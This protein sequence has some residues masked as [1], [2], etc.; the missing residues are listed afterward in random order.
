MTWIFLKPIIS[1]KL[2]ARRTIL[3]D[4]GRGIEVE[5]WKLMML[6]A[7]HEI[8]LLDTGLGQVE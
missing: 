2:A 3:R 4:Q 8:K 6:L 1:Y 5:S 7:L